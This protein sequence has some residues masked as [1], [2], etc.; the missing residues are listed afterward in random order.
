MLG[1]E[2]TTR[3]KSHHHTHALVHHD[4]SFLEGDKRHNHTLKAGHHSFPFQL[5]IDSALPSSIQT[6]AGEALIQY[7]L[8]ATVVR[9]G[10]TAHN[11][12]ATKMFDLQRTYTPDALEFNQTLEI[13]NTWP[14]KVMY[15]LTLPFKAY[16]AGDEIPVQVK[17]MPLAK[18]VRV[19]AVTSQLKEYTQVQTRHSSHSD[20]RV[21]A[22]CKHEFREGRAVQVS[23]EALKPPTHSLARWQGVQVRRASTAIGMGNAAAGPSSAVD[24]ANMTDEE[25]AAAAS[26]D[27]MHGDDEVNTIFSIFVPPWVTP[28]HT[29]HPVTV[30]HKLKWSCTI[31]NPDGHISELRCAL[32]IIILNHSLLDEARSAGANTRA[33]L[34]GETVDEA[35]NVDLPSYSNHVYDRVAADSGPATGYTS[36]SSRTPT[37]TH[38]PA[39]ATPPHSRPVSRPPS[40]PASPVRRESMIH[41]PIPGNP[42]R[43][44]LSFEADSELLRALGALEAHSSPSPSA[45]PAGSRGPS[46]PISRRGSFTRS[47]RSSNVNSRPGSRAASPDRSHPSSLSGS[48]ADDSHVRPGHGNER[49][50]TGLAARLHLPNAFKPLKPLSARPILRNDSDASIPR[51]ASSPALT[52]GGGHVSFHPKTARHDGRRLLG[53]GGGYFGGGGRS[54]GSGSGAG[55]HLASDSPGPGTPDGADGGDT[56]PAMDPISQVPCY[57]IALRGFASD[58]ANG[59]P[60]YDTSNQLEETARTKSEVDLEALQRTRSDTALMDLAAGEPIDPAEE[61]RAGHS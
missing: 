60:T 11:I 18:G 15:S 44:E 27:V 2:L 49:R 16:A 37:G 61:E 8:R 57:D 32:P 36:R 46:R 29:V 34:L 13:E 56:P 41:D 54:S 52:P 53:T 28:T 55:F 33:L 38:T 14:G 31:T 35:Q 30:T 59:P 5:M 17:F 19:T 25:V 1:P 58:M 51:N 45:T 50:S 43:R 48:Y 39:S 20:T 4:W 6:F 7:K 21:A 23:E 9:P 3:S 10:F 22:G 12:V 47:G 40:R 24:P 42:P 26:A